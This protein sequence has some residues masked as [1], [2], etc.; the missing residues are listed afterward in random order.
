[1]EN[2]PA[3]SIA[4][5]GGGFC[6]MIT[7]VH[8]LKSKLP[9]KITIIN[10]GYPFAKGVAYSAHTEKYILNVR[11]INM[12]AF[13]DNREHFL[14]WLLQ[15]KLYKAIVK[16]LVAN[17]YAPRR[18]YGEYLLEICQSALQNKNEKIHVELID[19][20]AENIFHD[21]FYRI[22]LSKGASAE[23]DYI[24]L[25][26][27]SSK[28]ANVF[29]DN[30]LISCKNYFSNPWNEDCVKDAHLLKNILIIG[31]GL[32]MVDTVLGLLENNFKGTINTISPNGFSLLPHK[33]NLLFYDK[34]L[35]DI[36]E[37]CSLQN[38]LSAVNKHAKLLAAAGIGTHLIIDA[39]CPFS[40]K[41]WQSF[42]IKE[43]QFFLKRLLHFWNSLRHRIPLHIF[44]LIQNLRVEN[45]LNTY[46]GKLKNVTLNNEKFIATIF[47]KVTNA[48][49]Q[50]TVDRIINCT[51]SENDIFKSENILLSNLA[52][53]GLITSD[54]LRMGIN[55]TSVGA[56]ITSNGKNQQ[57][58]FTLGNNLKGIL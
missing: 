47:N 38:L 43:K 24:I 18:M 30:N 3:P 11:A 55:A 35:D 48:E 22:N 20:F 52:T 5:I 33:Y 12:S 32:T 27:G 16:T 19:D 21:N 15:K 53:S 2:I 46:S 41:M 9:L 6:G 26:T 23:A 29:D 42:S 8:L 57:Q 56:V 39:L 51:G 13:P 45:I 44:V 58:N 14:N 40:Q 17:I 28:P 31:N 54:E 7:A 49:H 34:I 10:S 37:N 1:M 25:A 50:L 36:K 4:I